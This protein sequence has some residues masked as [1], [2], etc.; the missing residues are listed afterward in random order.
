MIENIT[1]DMTTKMDVF[2]NDKNKI[3]TDLSD[4]KT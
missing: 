3:I 2:E 4:F 1:S